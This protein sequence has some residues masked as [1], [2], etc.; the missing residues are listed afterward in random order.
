[1]DDRTIDRVFAGCLEELPPVSSK[2]VRIFT[3]ST[4]T[5]TGLERNTLMAEVYPKIKEYCREKHGL[6]FQVVDM[7][8]GVR[9]EATDDH[10]TTELCMR[11]IVNCQR[12][13]MGPNFVVFLGQKYGYRPIPTYILA[14]ELTLLKETLQQMGVDTHLLDLWY[15][16]DTNAVPPV[17]ILQPISTILVNFNNKRVP[18]LQSQDQAIWWDTLNKMQKLLRKAAHMCNVNG[19]MDND[20]MHNYFMS[21]TEREVINGVLNVENTKAHCIAYVRYINNI[22]LQNIKKASNFIDIIN[23]GI[24]AEAARLLGNLRDERLPNKIEASNMQKYTI[25][26]MGREGISRDTHDEYL[27]NFLAHF[28]KSITKL[29]DRAMR[30]ED[31][32][33]QGVIVT[34]ILQH[35]HACNNSVKVFYGREEAL[36]KAKDYMLGKSDKPLILY[37]AGGCGKTSLL[38][39]IAAMSFPWFNERKALPLLI[40]RFLGT[41]PDSSALAPMLISL[42]QQISYNFMLPM[43]DIPDDLVPLTAHFKQLITYG[44][45]EQPLIVFLDSVDQLTGASGANKL[46]WLPSKIPKHC[47]IVISCVNEPD[48]PE[49]SRDY[50]LL[51]RILDAEDHFIEVTALGEKLATQVMRKWLIAANRDV[52]N[53]QWRVVCNALAECSLP[54]FVKLV[55]A[56]TCRWKSYSKPND[57]LLATNVMDSIFKLFERIEMQHGRLLVTHAL[58]YVTAAKSGL[59]ETELEDLISMDDKVLDDVYQYH[60]PPVRRIPPLLWTRIRNDLPN[61][62]SER[63][64]DGVSVLSWYHRQF[65]DA[66]K[67]RYF[68]DE[69]MSIYF[70]SSIADYFLGLWGGGN[71]KPFQYTEIQRHR[72]GLK[73]RNAAADRKV[74]MQ[75]LVFVG[76]DGKISRYNLRKFGELPYHLVRA[77]RFS[78]LNESVLFNYQWLH[79]KISSCPLQSCL[80]DFEDACLY[81]EDRDSSRFLNLV[82]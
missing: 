44:T 76:K 73:D 25:E 71:P 39:Q 8:W 47:K 78:D 24:D 72:F 50:V 46:T 57:T 42:C 34:E 58:A 48:E 53:Y 37:G 29:V 21:V 63:E 68:K 9:D 14:T 15:K 40:L 66:A 4:F 7:R 2:I 17:M 59:S 43:E 77:K 79:A 80:S 56:E 60:L 16:K 1:M 19:K 5:D 28:Y 22:N 45:A 36:A 35:L 65:R 70:H 67:E 13:S 31:S 61:Y 52:T 64:A 74:P 62:L 18:K 82:S 38:A 49:I 12:L 75:P 11:E 20:A 10:M 23:R 27:S 26:W 54:I 81:M 41:T 51:R 33:A 6:E 32:S 3:S 30:K 55:F 69:A